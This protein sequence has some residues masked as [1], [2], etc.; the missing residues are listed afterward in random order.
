MKK[1]IPYILVLVLGFLYARECNRKTDPQIIERTIEVKVPEIIKQFDTIHK[2][3][4]KLI[5]QTDTIIL[6][7]YLSASDSLKI[8]LY[9]DATTE[10]EF[11]E[12]FKDSTQEVNVFTVVRGEMLEQ[13]LDYKIFERTIEHVEKFEVKEKRNFYL[14]PQ[15]G[16]DS[17]RIKASGSILYQDRKKRLI[18]IGI[19]TE[20]Y[21]MV[22]YGIKF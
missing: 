9:V 8:A 1:L 12:T 18:S 3:V 16:S 22:G 7:K 4:P 19:D 21:I 17:E 10:R 5:R 13:T 14:L 11:S 20:R 15:I 6:Q 2:P